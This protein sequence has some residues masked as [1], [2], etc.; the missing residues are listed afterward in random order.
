MRTKPAAPPLRMTED[1]F[2]ALA[3]E[4]SPWEYLG[5]EV[6]V[7]EPASFRHEDLFLFIGTLLRMFLD[8][9][10][11]GVALGSH[12]PMRLDPQWS[13]EPDLLVVC[14]AR[15]HLMGAQRLQGPAD[16]VIE[17][18]SPSDPRRDF[19][20]KLPRYR[21]AKVP[22]FWMIDPY[23]CRVRVETL[24]GDGYRVV[25]LWSGRLASTAVPGFWLDVAWLWQEPL[26]PTP[27][28]LRQILA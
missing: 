7:R 3:G 6:L 26:P 14:E 1:E 15:R 11:G 10:G 28:C 5:G 25:D 20:R 21:E 23:A 9:R 4:D 18:G 27:A 8:E 12:Y 17:I 19:R 24:E 13:P 22:E 16:L 2:Y